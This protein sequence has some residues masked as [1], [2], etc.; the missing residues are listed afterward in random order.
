MGESVRAKYERSLSMQMEL[1]RL[2]EAWE[3][4]HYIVYEHT[5]VEKISSRHTAVPFERRSRRTILSGVIPRRF[6]KE[7]R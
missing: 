1:R 4:D 2:A 6:E 7:I 3:G 5:A